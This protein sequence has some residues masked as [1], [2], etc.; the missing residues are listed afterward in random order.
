M[1]TAVVERRQFLPFFVPASNLSPADYKAHEDLLQTLQERLEDVRPTLRLLARLET[2]LGA[3]RELREVSRDAGRLLTRGNRD[4]EQLL[5]E[6]KLR[7]MVTRE[8]PTTL[9][10]LRKRLADYEQ[11]VGTPLLM[12]AEENVDLLGSPGN[13]R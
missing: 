7:N 12:T 1:R 11:F 6:E 3:K 10:T 9:R 5:R 8:L 4:P 13:S 2:L